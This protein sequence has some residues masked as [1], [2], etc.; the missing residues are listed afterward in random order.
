MTRCK[1][2]IEEN[3]TY[4]PYILIALFLTPNRD[5]INTFFFNET[6]RKMYLLV[7]PA[8]KIPTSSNIKKGIKRLLEEG[9][10]IL[11]EKH[12]DKNGGERLD[13]NVNIYK[14]LEQFSNFFSEELDS[15]KEEF[16][17]IVTILENLYSSE[18]LFLF[19]LLKKKREVGL[20]AEYIYPSKYELKHIKEEKDYV[21][22]LFNHKTK[23]LKRFKD[24]NSDLAREI[25]PRLS[26]DVKF[27]FSFTL[28]ELFK[29]NIIGSGKHYST[30]LKHGH[31]QNNKTLKGYSLD[32]QLFLQMCHFIDSSFIYDF[33][34]DAG[35]PIHD[36]KLINAL[37]SLSRHQL[38]R[39][40]TIK[41]SSKKSRR[42][43][44]S[45]GFSLEEE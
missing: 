2:P 45:D 30:L 27:S 23:I 42:K 44:F 35:D 38:K 34:P 31:L 4:T 26:S 10:F 36:E 19:D 11:Q 8:A 33:F 41:E 9:Y 24:L 37:G 5:Y 7:N 28:K 29:E 25:M 6:Y 17:G 21:N 39:I 18:N 13:F 20:P 32:H 1:T 40:P 3:K 15:K 14:I 16:D 12:E 43:K 22:K